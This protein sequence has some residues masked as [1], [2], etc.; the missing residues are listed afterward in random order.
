MS[1]KVRMWREVA[2]TRRTY[3][4][5]RPHITPFQAKTI[6]KIL[7]RLEREHPVPGST[8]TKRLRKKRVKA[9]GW[10]W[11]RPEHHRARPTT[12]KERNRARRASFREL[13]AW[14]KGLD[15]KAKAAEAGTVNRQL[16]ELRNAVAASAEVAKGYTFDLDKI[17]ALI[18]AAR[19]K[20]M[21][22]TPEET[23]E[24]LRRVRA[25]TE[26]Q[27]AEL[28]RSLGVHSDP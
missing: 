8:R 10:R 6:R 7:R 20:R 18:A 14:L 1:R 23:A 15:V 2:E 27:I 28:E 19:Q 9:R 5:I 26:G 21:A 3:E 22:Q 12:A 13:T 11:F 24:D 25:R 4:Q 16:R 17:A